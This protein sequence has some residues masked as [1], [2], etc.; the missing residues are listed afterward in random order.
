VTSVVYTRESLLYPPHSPFLIQAY[1]ISAVDTISLKNYTCLHVRNGLQAY[2]ISAFDTLSL[3]NHTCSYVR[4]GFLD[5]CQIS[6]QTPERL[7]KLEVFAT[8]LFL[9]VFC[10]E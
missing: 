9:L 3:K 4:N 2:I 10:R 7:V 5:F 1:I 6:R 8:D